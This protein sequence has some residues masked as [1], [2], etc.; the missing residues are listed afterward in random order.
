M[1]EVSTKRV[2]GDSIMSDWPANMTTEDTKELVDSEAKSVEETSTA[3]LLVGIA[4]I[5][6]AVGYA[7]TK[8]HNV[9]KERGY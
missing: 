9:A 2:G 3:F 6:V 7:T 8:L 1:L 4:T 5:I